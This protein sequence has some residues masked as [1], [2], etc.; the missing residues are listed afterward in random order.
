LMTLRKRGADHNFGGA[1]WRTSFAVFLFI[2][3]SFG[4]LWEGIQSYWDTH[5]GLYCYGC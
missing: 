5:S 2:S 1:S 4:N 3:W